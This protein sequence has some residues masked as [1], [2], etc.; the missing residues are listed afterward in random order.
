[1]WGEGDLGTTNIRSVPVVVGV[2]Q[3]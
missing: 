3:S 2:S 1:L